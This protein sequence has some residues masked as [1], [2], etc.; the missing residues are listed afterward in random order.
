MNNIILDICS[1]CGEA[2]YP[3]R[4][5]CR[6]CLSDQIIKK[7]VSAF[8]KIISQIDLRHSLEVS[9]LKKLPWKICTIQLECG[10][11]IMAHLAEPLKA[12]QKAEIQNITD[13]TGAD[14]WLVKSI[15]STQIKWEKLGGKS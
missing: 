13:P 8:G 6:H 7:N 14:C 5:I 4:E 11:I 2:Q 9:F 12:G 1:Q 10:A 15:G 3:P